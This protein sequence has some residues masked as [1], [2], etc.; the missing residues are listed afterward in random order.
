MVAIAPDYR[1]KN[2]QQT[3]PFES[4]KDAKS[5]VRWT[6]AHAG[7]LGIDPQRIA[8]AGSS[9]GG[10]VAA[11]SVI[12]P[13]FDEAN[14]NAA[15]SSSPNALVLFNP[16]ID[17]SLNGYGNE[18]LGARWQE[19]SPLQH[20][21]PGLPP[22]IVF[23]G[24]ADKTVPY[25]N[26]VDFEKAMKAAGNRCELVTFRGIGHGFA[27][28]LYNK[29]ANQAARDTDKFLASLGYLQGEPTLAAPTK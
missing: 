18:R 20:V 17:T 10:H 9:A 19:I 11:C 2:R 15:V 21:R 14:E 25:Q 26:A 16:V 29:A 13:G 5:V 28:R 27:Y 22:T 24:T 7:E 12:V 1:V 6:R 4:V 23:H 3:T 8:A